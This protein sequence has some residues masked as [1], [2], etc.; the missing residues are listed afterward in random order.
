M[1]DDE[2]LLRLQAM[3]LKQAILL[4]ELPPLRQAHAECLAERDRLRSI[5]DC[6]PAVAVTDFG[7]VA[8]VRSAD[9]QRAVLALAN[10]LSESVA[11]RGLL[12]ELAAERES[13]RGE[14]RDLTAALN[15]QCNRADEAEKENQELTVAFNN[16]ALLCNEAMVENA[17][18][19]SMLESMGLASA[20]IDAA[21]APARGSDTS[22]Q[23]QGDG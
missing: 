13:L 4:A 15:R 6:L 12:L 23:G 21:L 10:A 18:L 16:R 9:Y 1:T 7:G 3:L 19:R 14:R 22:P 5:P 20:V 8:Y 17:A 11:A 2:E